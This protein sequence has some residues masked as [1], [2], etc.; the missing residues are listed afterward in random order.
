[1]TDHGVRA[2][3]AGGT[4]GRREG[5]GGRVA[6]RAVHLRTGG[7]RHADRTA[8]G[9]PGRRPRLVRAGPM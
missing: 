3:G 1:A 4:D 2:R 8:V 9:G 5:A 7:D 6:V